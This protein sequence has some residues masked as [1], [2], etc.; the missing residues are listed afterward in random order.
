MTISE[1][2]PV[3]IGNWHKYLGTAIVVLIVL[4]LGNTILF[5]N[6][7]TY[8]WNQKL[9]V[10]VVTPE[11]ERSGS[12][13][14]N[15]WV[16]LMTPCQYSGMS[17][18]CVRV[19]Q[20]GEATIVDLPDNQHLF[21]LLPAEAG[22]LAQDTFKSIF[23]AIKGAKLD[24]AR[25]FYAMLQ[26]YHEPGEVPPDAY[27]RT[28]FVTFDNLDDPASVKLVDP[29][30]LAATFGPGYA[31]KSV[32][33]EVTYEPVEFGKVEEILPWIDDYRNVHFDGS[34]IESANAQNRLANSL[35]TGSFKTGD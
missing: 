11:G 31:L 20:K 10:T 3:L 24:G 35:G 30:D 17:Q 15:G 2:A 19:A 7:Q 21:I 14:V 22:Y 18:A 13:V 9:T 28:R 16:S 4:M 1:R 12:A 26:N 6:W 5:G 32:T 27:K 33:L 23:E 8:S 29:A 34:R 25:E